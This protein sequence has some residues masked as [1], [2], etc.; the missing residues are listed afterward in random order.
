MA[1]RVQCLVKN[2][3]KTVEFIN[4]R[5]RLAY[6]TL[7]HYSIFTIKL[8]REYTNKISLMISNIYSFM[9]SDGNSICGD[10]VLDNFNMVCSDEDN[11]EDQK[12]EKRIF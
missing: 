6:E 9:Q 3:D 7:F 5:S 11:L 4:H 8:R 12:Y 10:V 2:K 1:Y